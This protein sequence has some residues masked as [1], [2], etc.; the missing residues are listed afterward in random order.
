MLP[1]NLLISIIALVL[2]IAILVIVVFNYMR[3]LDIPTKDDSTTDDTTIEDPE[4]LY[5]FYSDLA[6]VQELDS[7]GKTFTVSVPTADAHARAFTNIPYHISFE[8][9]TGSEG[10]ARILNTS[11]DNKIDETQF[12]TLYQTDPLLKLIVD[13]FND[14]D[15][16]FISELPNTTL[17][18]TKLTSTSGHSDAQYSETIAELVS[19]TV[20]ASDTLMEFK[21]LSNE[22]V[23]PAGTYDHVSITIDNWFSKTFRHATHVV[24]VI[25]NEIKPVAE[26][27]SGKV[28]KTVKEAV[29]AVP[30]VA[31]R[32]FDKLG[33][34]DPDLLLQTTVSLISTGAICGSAVLGGNA[35][36]A[37]DCTVSMIGT[38]GKTVDLVQS[39]DRAHINF[40]RRPKDVLKSRQFVR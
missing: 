9:D 8:I 7:D 40:P 25:E 38:V 3:T 17:S 6:T 5:L 35:A 37:A 1:V 21:L 31:D 10:L 27:I 13:D 26:S 11:K 36:A 2:V 18:F 14:R 39:Y 4:L 12:G 15:Q 19:F 32:I 24:D 30:D 23:I 20:N 16:P 33:E 28:V 29:D 22:Q 34:T